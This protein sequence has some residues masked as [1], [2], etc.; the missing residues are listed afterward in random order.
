MGD[1][2]TFF[3]SHYENL[4]K[5]EP[6]ILKELKEKDIPSSSGAYIIY[7]DDKKF[8]YPKGESSV[9]YIGMSQNLRQRITTHKKRTR[10]VNDQQMD[11]PR[12]E[13][14]A[15]CNARII[16]IKTW[17]GMTPKSL[18][19]HLLAHFAKK[20]KSF[21]VANGVGAWNKINAVFSED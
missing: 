8:S 18:E 19:D 13:Y 5:S 16:W 15:T 6:L 11:W 20:Y 14:A 3:E 17:Q 12:Y 7:A 4:Q 2:L 1:Y 21:P 9:F 10:E